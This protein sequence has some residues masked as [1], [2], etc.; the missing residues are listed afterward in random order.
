MI[1]KIAILIGQLMRIKIPIL[2]F[3]VIYPVCNLERIF[4]L[5]TKK[6]KFKL[7]F[8]NSVKPACS[9]VPGSSRGL[10]FGTNT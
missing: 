9:T 2:I 4:L 6:I 5:E 1:M 7:T 10:N 8:L 3:L